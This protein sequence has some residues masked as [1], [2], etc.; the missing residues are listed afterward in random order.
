[1]SSSWS[2]CTWG[3]HG[4]SRGRGHRPGRGRA[5]THQQVGP[6]PT[7]PQ[8]LQQHLLDQRQLALARGLLLPGLSLRGGLAERAVHQHPLAHGEV[9]HQEHQPPV[10]Q[11]VD[12]RGERGQQPREAGG[13]GGQGPAR[14]RGLTHLHGSVLPHQQAPVRG[15]DPERGGVPVRRGLAA[16]AGLLLA[17]AEERARVP[18]QHLLLIVHGGARDGPAHESPMARHRAP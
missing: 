8:R 17:G 12:L 5:H 1:M 18:V 11:L 10:R 7:A 9:L 4:V 13:S 15:L 6:A 14:A 3:P 16:P 2:T